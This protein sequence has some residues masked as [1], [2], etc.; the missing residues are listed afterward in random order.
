MPTAPTALLVAAALLPALAFAAPPT[1]A[2]PVK[3]WP[4]EVREVAYRSDADGTDQPALW[5][6]PP[7]DAPVPLLVCLHTW[8]SDYRTAEPAYATGC[9]DRGWA[10]VRPNFRG[11]NSKPDACG[12]DL[13]VKDVLAAVVW[14]KSQRKIDPDRVYLIGGS[15]GGH[16]S[17]LVA[18][19]SPAGTWA[20]VSAWCPIS[21]LARWHA[22]SK[23]RKNRY[24]EML[25]KSCGGPPGASPDVD[26]QY[27]ARSPLTHLASAKGTSIQ[28]STG[29]T[30]GHNGSVPVGHTLRAFNALAAEADRV[31]EADIAAM[32]AKPQMP[33]NLLMKLADPLFAGKNAALFQRTSGSARVTIFQGGHTLLPASGMAWLAEQRRGK[34]PVWDVKPPA[35]GEATDV[36]K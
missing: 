26:R 36:A 17:L 24:W 5:Y 30:D 23:A 28:I 19:R 20:G 3:G 33:P 34:P 29:I 1:T 31:S 10:M 25:E 35:G 27:A 11:P 2:P 9:I 4:P 32:E 15:G 21:D 12:S 13:A 22:D 14:A 6:A 18:G 7:G 8:S 16:M